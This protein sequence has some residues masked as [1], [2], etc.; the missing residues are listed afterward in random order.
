MPFV[1]VSNDAR[2]H[3]PAILIERVATAGLALTRPRETFGEKLAVI[4]QHCLDLE[5][6]PSPL[7]AS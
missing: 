5:V 6:V 1:S 7:P 4:V 3:G 2:Y